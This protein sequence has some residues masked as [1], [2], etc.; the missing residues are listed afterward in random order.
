MFQSSWSY[1]QDH[2]QKLWEVPLSE[3]SSSG[4][5]VSNNSIILKTQVNTTGQL[6]KISMDGKNIQTASI[7]GSTRG[8]P[9][10]LNNVIYYNTSVYSL[11]ALNEGDLSIIWSKTGFVWIPIPTVDEN[12]VYITDLDVVSAVDKATGNTIWSKDIYGK[13]GAN[14]VIDGNTIYFAT[15]GIFKGDGYLYSINKS[16]GSIIYEIN[17]PYFE[18]K[19]QFGGSRAGVEIWN[20]QIYVSGDNRIFY[21]FNKNSGELLW[22]FEADAPI[23]AT[24]RVSDGYVYFGTLN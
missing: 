14:P 22:T 15:G 12:Y 3:L 19:S 8:V 24:S 18:D 21:C 11:Y 5:A 23:E 1:I 20:D 16:N 6:Y 4:F 17:I 7:S 2:L 13:N 10:V 9:V